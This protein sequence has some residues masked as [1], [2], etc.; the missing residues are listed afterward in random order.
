MGVARIPL[1]LQHLLAVMVHIVG[2][3]LCDPLILEL[4]LERMVL[5]FVWNLF[6][7]R[8]LRVF[9]LHSEVPV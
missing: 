3:S 5:S 4:L 6:G 7:N 2:S 9:Y 8:T 1:G